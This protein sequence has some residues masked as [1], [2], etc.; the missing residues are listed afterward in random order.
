VASCNK[1]DLIERDPA[2]GFAGLPYATG[3]AL[4]LVVCGLA[5]ARL[6]AGAKQQ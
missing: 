2:K 6:A 3:F 4:F 1:R 5:L